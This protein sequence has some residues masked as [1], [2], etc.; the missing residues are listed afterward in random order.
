MGS[1]AA[2]GRALSAALAALALLVPLTPTIALAAASPTPTASPTAHPPTATPR[3]PTA[4]PVAPTPTP[5]PP[6]ATPV[7]PTA[8][9]VPPSPTSAPTHPPTSTSSPL[10]TTAPT[11]SSAPASPSPQPVVSLGPASPAATT[12]PAPTAPSTPSPGASPS[13]VP[14]TQLPTDEATPT[15]GEASEDDATGAAEQLNGPPLTPAPGIGALA[16]PSASS[17]ASPEATS[18]AVTGTPDT[19]PDAT[20]TATDSGGDSADPADSGA[21]AEAAASP[22]FWRAFVPTDVADHL[23]MIHQ[24]S[25]DSSCK[26]PWQVL[27]AIARVES[28]FGQNMSTSSAGAIG[29]GQFLPSS[30]DAFGAAGNAYDYRDALPAIARYLCTA[31]AGQ[32]LR[33]ALFAYNHA[34]WYVN[35]VLAFAVRYDHL[36][37]NNPTPRILDAAPSGDA[38]PEL[39]YAPG[40]DVTLARQR[41][42]LADGTL[43]LGVPFHARV[44]AAG[45]RETSQPGAALA[46]IAAVLGGAD[47]DSVADAVDLEND[48]ASGDMADV[49]NA[50]WASDLLP[51][52]LWG[53]P[54]TYRQWS[55]ADVRNHVA[56]G[57]PVLTLVDSRSMP[58]VDPLYSQLDHYV[59][60]VGLTPDG[61]I[62]NDGT[63]ASTLGYGLTV[64]NAQLETAWRNASIPRLAVAFMPKPALAPA[65][66]E[67]EAVQGRGGPAA[68]PPTPT[69]V[70][71]P[72]AAPA[73]AVPTAVPALPTP[74]PNWAPEALPEHPSL[75]APQEEA[76]PRDRAPGLVVRLG[77]LVLGA[78]VLVMAAAAA[79]ELRKLAPRR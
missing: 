77:L 42:Q 67:R 63:F 46:M 18:D 17:V 1:P 50:G 39:R 25:T 34:D 44:K 66:A 29:Y 78:L 20:D 10:A 62:Y 13:P 4:T 43:W 54:Y 31:G 26:V 16:S 52:D 2:L 21:A 68:D 57:H 72:T 8:S 6:T 58:G 76:E 48:D 15:P 12:S 79:G 3:P 9:P 33:R 37:P 41:R 40:R 14:P 38:G 61:V 49:A 65:P 22:A 19:P 30:W 75:P 28:D 71:Q 55:V 45:P 60:I 53:A 36:A 64:S 51:L 27:A 70:P 56:N 69:P 32:D 24:A 35:M 74:E 5:M 73:T 59:V 7:P 11:A 47:P 23:A